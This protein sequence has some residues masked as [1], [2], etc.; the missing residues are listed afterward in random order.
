[1]KNKTA[2]NKWTYDTQTGWWQ[3]DREE[4]YSRTHCLACQKPIDPQGDDWRGCADDEAICNACSGVYEYGWN[5]DKQV[6]EQI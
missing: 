6:W 1:M 2:N 5:E 4:S 3:A